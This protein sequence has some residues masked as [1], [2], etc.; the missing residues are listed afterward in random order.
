MFT[1]LTRLISPNKKDILADA[2]SVF[3]RLSQFVPTIDLPA[4]FVCIFAR[5]KNGGLPPSSRR[6]QQS[7][8]LLRLDYSN[9][10]APISPNKKDI[11]TDVL[12]VWRYRPDL[13]WRIRVL[14]TRAL[15]LG[16]GTI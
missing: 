11:L 3:Y 8:G 13:N 14:Q 10:A 16:H 2:V 5:G 4:R 9:L 12:F 6:Q 7:T 15:P 1:V